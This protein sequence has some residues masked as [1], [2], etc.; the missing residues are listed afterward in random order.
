MKKIFSTLLALLLFIS[1]LGLA[2]NTHFCG[3]EAVE[4]SVTLGLD[5]LNC[6]MASMEEPCENNQQQVKSESCCENQHDILQ[7]DEDFEF[8]SAPINLNPIF[9]TA[10]IHSFVQPL[11]FF[12]QKHIQYKAYDP[13][14]PSKDV[15][16]LY[17]AFLI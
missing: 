11:T 9:I 8:N 4:T 5:N 17:Q 3:G 12:E 15:Q 14:I 10:L 2:M 6:G 16:V 13:P 7:I 1:N